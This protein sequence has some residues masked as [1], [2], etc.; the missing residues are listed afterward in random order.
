MTNKDA[1][2]RAIDAVAREVTGGSPSLG[3]P[4]RVRE[5]IERPRAARAWVWQLAGAL[6]VLAVIAYVSWPDGQKTDS[7][8][9]VT[10]PVANRPELPPV[11]Q[12]APRVSRPHAGVVARRV[13]RPP[14][15]DTPRPRGARIPIDVDA[16]QIAALG[17]VSE[18][19]VS[20]AQPRDLDLPDL[21][22]REVMIPPL[23]PGDKERP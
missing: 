18:L 3:F 21:S 4:S 11:A 12:V 9:V 2:D 16:P 14:R 7:P 10:G 23:E 13:E 8:A 15:R 17:R 6:A 19:T 20:V 22:V 5:R 1:L